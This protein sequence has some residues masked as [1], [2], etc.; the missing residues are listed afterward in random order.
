MH[1]SADGPMHA[2]THTYSVCSLVPAPRC[3]CCCL[4]LVPVAHSLHLCGPVTLACML[5][6]LCVCGGGGEQPQAQACS[7]L[8]VP[9]CTAL[10]CT[11][12]GLYKGGFFADLPGVIVRGL[13]EPYYPL[14]GACPAFSGFTFFPAKDIAGYDLHLITH[15]DDATVAFLE[16]FKEPLCK[17]FNT[18]MQTMYWAPSDEPSAQLNSTGACAGVYVKAKARSQCP[19]FPGYKF[20]PQKD[21]NQAYDIK[22]LSGSYSRLELYRACL[23]TPGCRAFNTDAHLKF[24]VAPGGPTIDAFKGE[25]CGG[26][27]VRDDAGGH[28]C[29]GPPG[30]APGR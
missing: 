7:C 3:S 24:W 1:Q 28:A 29:V 10:R 9:R 17:A 13:T 16:C 26:V 14:P 6:S 8:T 15:T 19:Q 25:D 27:Y 5:L 11:A 20:Y 12:G 4:H 21:V 30:G 2:C 18:E 22:Q 23:A